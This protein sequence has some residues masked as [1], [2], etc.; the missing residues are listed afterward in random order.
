MNKDKI[1]LEI[2]KKDSR[3]AAWW[4]KNDYKVMRVV[5][6]FIWI[7]MWLHRKY[8][9]RKKKQFVEIPSKT[10]KWLDKVFH[11]MVAHY[12]NE[13]EEILIVL[14]SDR[15]NCGD[16]STNDFANYNGIG[17]RAKKYF[18][19]LTSEQRQQMIMGYDIE[20]YEKK[21]LLCRSDWEEIEQQLGWDTN[22]N[23]D[24]CKAVVFYDNNK[25]VEQ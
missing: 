1:I 10:K 14:G 6:W 5:L 15:E 7:P 13:A 25:K 18:E 2:N 23:E 12:C 20:G 3:L 4:H 24:Y 21:L 19:L 8:V 9:F 17:K 16:F 22:W 11:K